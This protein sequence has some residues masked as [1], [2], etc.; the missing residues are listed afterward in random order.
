MSD[1]RTESTFAAVLVRAEEEI[2][3]CG[4]GSQFVIALRRAA[5]RDC[6]VDLEAPVG[7]FGSAF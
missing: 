1:V 5:E 2:A 7:A 3:A 6:V 4:C